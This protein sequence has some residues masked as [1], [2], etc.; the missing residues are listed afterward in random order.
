M[1]DQHVIAAPHQPFGDAPAG[2]PSATQDQYAHR[3]IAAHGAARA[4]ELWPRAGELWPR[5]ETV[6]HAGS[7]DPLGRS[8]EPAA[9][10]GNTSSLPLVLRPSKSLCARAASGSE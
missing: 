1:H 6:R 5:G 7:L 8:G 2:E 9:L 4:G 10:Y 3:H